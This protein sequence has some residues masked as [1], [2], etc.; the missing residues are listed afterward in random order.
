MWP[1]IPMT[2]KQI[3]AWFPRYTGQQW[4][5]QFKPGLGLPMPDPL[6]PPPRRPVSPTL[7]TLARVWR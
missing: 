2:R 6:E 3:E 5:D 7:E 1:L 4:V